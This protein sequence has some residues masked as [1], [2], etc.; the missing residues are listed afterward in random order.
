MAERTFTIPFRGVIASVRNDG[1]IIAPGGIEPIDLMQLAM[2]SPTV[3]PQ[4]EIEGYMSNYDLEA[5]TVD[6]RVVCA[7]A[8]VGF[9]DDLETFIRGTPDLRAAE[10]SMI[11]ANEANL[12]GR[13]RAVSVSRR[14]EFQKGVQIRQADIDRW[15]NHRQR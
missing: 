15:K 5:G 7:E 11:E 2:E 12:D 14:A 4:P 8:D 6:C 13:E 9:L 10:L 3:R 1:H